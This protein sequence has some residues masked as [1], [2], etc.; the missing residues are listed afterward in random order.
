MKATYKYVGPDKL[1]RMLTVD[2]ET[3]LWLARMLVGE[4]GVNIDMDEAAA[5][6]WALL[7]RWFL[8]PGR[9]H[10]PTFLGMVRKNMRKEN[11]FSVESVRV[12]GILI[13]LHNKSLWNEFL[14]ASTA[15]RL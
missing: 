2:D 8:H 3:A 14:R 6:L 10:W 9:R 11:P 1:K 7:N 4:G 12:G 15:L 5:C 13:F